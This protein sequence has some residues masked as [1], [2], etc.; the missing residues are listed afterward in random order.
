MCGRG[1]VAGCTC[2]FDADPGLDAPEAKNRAGRR[3]VKV[4]RSTELLPD[5]VIDPDCGV[6]CGFDRDAWDTDMSGGDIC[7]KE[8]DDRV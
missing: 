5:R 3:G 8:K 2:R 1:A 7:D 4:E 6:Y